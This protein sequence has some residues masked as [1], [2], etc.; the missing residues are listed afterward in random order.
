[1]P[2]L[3]IEGDIYIDNERFLV[4]LNAPWSNAISGKA[5]FSVNGDSQILY[6]DKIIYLNGVAVLSTDNTVGNARYSTLQTLA[7][8][9]WAIDDNVDL[10][11]DVTY[12]VNFSSYNSNYSQIYLNGSLG[13]IK[14]YATKVY[15]ADMTGWVDQAYR[16]IE[17][18]GGTDATNAS[19]ISWLQ[20]NA[21][22]QVEP[23]PSSNKVTFGNLPIASISFGNQKVTKMS[24]GDIDIYSDEEPSV[25]YNVTLTAS[26]NW[27]GS[28]V[29][30]IYIY[31]GTDRTGM[32]VFSQSPVNKSAYPV[33]VQISSG[34]MYIYGTADG[35]IVSDITSSDFAG[36]GGSSG[37]DPV[38]GTFTGI[39]HDGTVN[40][41]V[42]DWDD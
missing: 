42:D 36:G 19:L 25:A 21:V 4:P 29:A 5:D 22:Q 7:G 14:Y 30:S 28:S 10:S 32:L 38:E 6:K 33:T 20:A 9:K 12:N 11:G 27:Y 13:R 31:D 2:P 3:P 40:L 37:S 16:T 39:D 24:L 1:M 34:S 15:D 41:D 8:T 17:I 35:A 26:G 23:E 18:T